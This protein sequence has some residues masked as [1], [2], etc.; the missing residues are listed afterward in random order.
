MEFF[1]LKIAL[2]IALATAIGYRIMPVFADT[3]NVTSDQITQSVIVDVRTP[4]E[5]KTAHYHG[6]VNIPLDQI[7]S[8]ISKIKG[9]KQPIIVYC[10]SGNR[11]AKA[12]A[13]LKRNGIPVTNGINQ[14]TL[15]KA[16]RSKPH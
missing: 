14:A 7:D 10:R 9:M 6:A 12:A 11:S 5:Y 15:E 13:I 16:S 2:I 1:M 3:A 4:E 8:Q